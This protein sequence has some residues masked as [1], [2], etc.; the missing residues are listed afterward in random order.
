MIEW[1]KQLLGLKSDLEKKQDQIRKL[2]EKAFQAQRNG[3]LSLAGE[4]QQQAK[5]IAESIEQ[6]NN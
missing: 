5:K 1:I 2:E 3:D 6:S 4:Y